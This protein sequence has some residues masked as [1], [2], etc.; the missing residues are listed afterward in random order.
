MHSVKP[1]SLRRKLE[2]KNETQARAA[3]SDSPSSISN[4]STLRRSI[5]GNGIIQGSLS[6]LTIGTALQLS[7]NHR[8]VV[9]CL[10]AHGKRKIESMRERLGLTS[11]ATSDGLNLRSRLT[12]RLQDAQKDGQR[13]RE[14]VH[15]LSNHMEL[16]MAA[17]VAR[18]IRMHSR[19]AAFSASKWEWTW[20]T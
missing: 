16:C 5:S 15:Q 13:C 14:S 12:S 3:M 9:S 17:K 19:R 18:N 10:T 2:K 4:T 7:I 11:R 1:L 6:R 20:L 8:S